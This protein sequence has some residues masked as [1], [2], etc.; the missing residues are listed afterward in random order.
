LAGGADDEGGDGYHYVSFHCLFFLLFI[1]FMDERRRDAVSM[2]N[3]PPPLKC[4]ARFWLQFRYLA[5][6]GESRLRRDQRVS[7]YPCVGRQFRESRLLGWG[8]QAEALP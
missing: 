4:S 7:Q 6:L 5:D 8:Q 2:S 3:R 1:C